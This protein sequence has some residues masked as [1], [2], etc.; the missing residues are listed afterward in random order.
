VQAEIA[1]AYLAGCASVAF[2]W[3]LAELINKESNK[4]E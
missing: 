2:C 3:W 1:L 4:D